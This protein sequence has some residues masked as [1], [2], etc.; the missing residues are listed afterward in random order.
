MACEHYIGN[1]G[2][3]LDT[4][5]FDKTRSAVVTTKNGWPLITLIHPKSFGE[6]QTELQVD[7]G[8]SKAKIRSALKKMLQSK[9]TGKVVLTALVDQFS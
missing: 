8:E 5:S 3:T 4:K 9:S 6:A 1:Y 7:G 2:V